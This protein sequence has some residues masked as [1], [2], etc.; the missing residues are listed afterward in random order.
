M[1]QYQKYTRIF[2]KTLFVLKHSPI[3]LSLPGFCVYF[4]FI[5]VLIIAFLV[6]PGKFLEKN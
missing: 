6:N 1:Q 5:L 3:Y 4:T 2:F